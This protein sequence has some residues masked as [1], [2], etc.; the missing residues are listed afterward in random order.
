MSEGV[1]TQVHVLGENSLNLS[2]DS[3]SCRS[4]YLFSNNCNRTH[5]QHKDKSEAISQTS[6][7]VYNVYILNIYQSLN[8]HK[9]F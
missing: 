3:R 6:H 4:V 7:K 1:S 5:S 2:Q 8:S 9:C